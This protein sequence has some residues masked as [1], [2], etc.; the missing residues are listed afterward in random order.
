MNLSDSAKPIV[1]TTFT[2][3]PLVLCKDQY[4][5]L[6][7]IYGQHDRHIVIIP[8]SR[9]EKPA[10]SWYRWIIEAK[11]MKSWLSNHLTSAS[12]L[13]ASLHMRFLHRLSPFVIPPWSRSIVRLAAFQTP[14]KFLGQDG[15]AIGEVGGLPWPIFGYP[16]WFVILKSIRWNTLL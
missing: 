10:W 15:I 2:L 12:T 5:S 8:G 13:C 16:Q 14:K 9:W 4:T 3:P 7:S 6:S 11:N 1:W